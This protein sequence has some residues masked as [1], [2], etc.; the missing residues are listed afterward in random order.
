M[1]MSSNRSIEK[2]KLGEES[3]GIASRAVSNER[4]SRQQ[5]IEQ[6]ITEWREA[7][8]QIFQTVI[9]YIARKFDYTFSS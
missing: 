9:S 1:G 6:F 5:S 3:F 2:W 7:K 4:S 8:A